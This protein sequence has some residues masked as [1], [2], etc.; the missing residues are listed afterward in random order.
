MYR[1]CTG[2]TMFHIQCTPYSVR[3][4]VYSILSIGSRMR[5]HSNPVS[6]SLLACSI[7]P[8][9]SIS[10]LLP[11]TLYMYNVQCTLYNVHCT[12]PF[13]LLQC[14]PFL[15]KADLSTNFDLFKC[16]SLPSLPFRAKLF[17][18]LTNFLPF[19]DAFSPLSI[20]PS[21][22]GTISNVMLD[23]H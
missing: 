18:L 12:C 17:S 22:Y 2:H 3:C 7:C 14:S 1:H 10:G 5:L 23:K 11:A 9:F 16:L 8:A 6:P 21:H 20:Y 13:G 4:T 15:P 19:H